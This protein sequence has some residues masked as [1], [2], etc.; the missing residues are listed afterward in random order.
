MLV[1]LQPI[2]SDSNDESGSES[3]TNTAD[4]VSKNAPFL[5][6]NVVNPRHKRP[7]SHTYSSRHTDEDDGEQQNCAD[8]CSWDCDCKAIEHLISPLG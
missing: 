7:Q 1:F 3:E 2:R 8:Y 5:L 6:A 4:D